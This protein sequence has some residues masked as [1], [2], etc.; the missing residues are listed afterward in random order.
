MTGLT[1][2]I[3][4]LGTEWWINKKIL[5]ECIFHSPTITWLWGRLV[6]ISSSWYIVKSSMV[7][8][9]GNRI[10]HINVKCGLGFKHCLDIFLA[11]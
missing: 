11:F 6:T 3:S 9:C 10:E 7:S 8:K 2:T 4:R 5:I 1:S